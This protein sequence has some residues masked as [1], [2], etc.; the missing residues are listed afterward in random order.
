MM[1][2][3]V[4]AVRRLRDAGWTVDVARPLQ[5]L[6]RPDSASLT[7]AERV[8]AAESS[9]RIRQRGRAFRQHGALPKGT[10]VVV[11]D[12]VTTG[13]TLAAVM[14]RL[15]GAN[16]QVAG[17]ATLAATQLRRSSRRGFTG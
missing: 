16:L 17:A 10:L 2:L 3:A 15:R 6:P 12:I 8:A 7:P 9:L 14:R 4:H 11:D 5:A 13:A 1:R